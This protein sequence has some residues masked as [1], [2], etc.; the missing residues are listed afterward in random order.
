MATLSLL[1]S[2]GILGFCGKKVVVVE[3][4]KGGMNY[5]YILYPEAL[6]SALLL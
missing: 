1:S 4:H 3:W 2:C 5:K 6:G